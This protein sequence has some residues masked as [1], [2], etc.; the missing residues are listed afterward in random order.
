MNIVDYQGS[1]IKTTLRK[2]KSKPQ[3]LAFFTELEHT[4]LK[5]V[6]THERH[7]SE[8]P[9]SKTTQITDWRKGNCWWAFK[10]VAA[11]MENSVEDSHKT[12]KRTTIWTSN[13]TPW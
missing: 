13:S 6:W 12:K 9:P 1:T 8:W 10:L 4:I 3:Y 7:L 5:F 2:Y 11:A